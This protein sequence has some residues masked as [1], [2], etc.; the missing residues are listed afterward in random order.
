[1]VPEILS[2]RISESGALTV[3]K[4][5]V[6]VSAQ[7]PAHRPRRVVMVNAR[8]QHWMS[9]D[10]AVTALRNQKCSELLWRK[11]VLTPD[12]PRSLAR[13]AFGAEPPTVV[14][15]ATTLTSR[16]LDVPPLL[17]P[18][19]FFGMVGVVTASIFTT[20]L[21]IASVPLLLVVGVLRSPAAVAL[22]LDCA[23][24]LWTHCHPQ[25]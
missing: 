23:T 24:L 8:I 22:T 17:S 4:A 20:L 2:R 11:T 25:R 12:V 16:V 7:Q 21:A 3:T 10:V 13:A 5:N 9:A 18:P 6:T 1:M 15:Y 19:F 14:R